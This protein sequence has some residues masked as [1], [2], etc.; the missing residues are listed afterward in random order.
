M[1]L[2]NMVHF[3]DITMIIAF[4]MNEDNHSLICLLIKLLCYNVENDK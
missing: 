4:F 2:S 1:C 3:T